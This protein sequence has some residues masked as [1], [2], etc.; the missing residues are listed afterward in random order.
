[1]TPIIEYQNYR[2]Y[3]LDY[4][5]HQKR[6]CVFSW[7]E[8]AKLSG[9]TNPVYLKQV[10]DGKYNLSK[11]AVDRVGAAM[12]LAGFELT[13]FKTLVEF[14]HA[15]TDSDKKR[16]FVD[17][18]AIAKIHKVKVLGG[19]A[20]TYFES[21]KNPV[22][23]ELAPAMPGAKPLAIAKA[24]R[25][26]ITA[27]EV[28]ETLNF[29]VKTGLLTKDK[30]GCYH[31]T[32]KSISMGSMDAAPVAARIMQREMGAFAMMALDAL[33]LSERNMSGL[34]LGLT[35]KAYEKIVAELAE[36]RKRVVAIA[37]EDD[38]MENVYRMNF[39][40]FPLTRLGATS[41]NDSS[42]NENVKMKKEYSENEADV[43]LDNQNDEG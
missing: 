40:L 39:H 19:D 8:F 16:A 36:F 3:I 34:T 27:A 15:K 9:F 26:E 1:M 18:Q 38:G 23:R 28:S 31:Q 25:P 21:W 7:R 30:E 33:P 24:C 20:F 14:A 13:Y 6:C 43:E 41:E 37:T 4:Y 32:E 29:L 2:K 5:N 17:L 22:L 11:K 35:K 12:G 10:C 42:Y